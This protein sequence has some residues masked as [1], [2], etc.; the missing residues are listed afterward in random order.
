MGDH[1]PKILVLSRNYPNRAVPLLGVWVEGL[2]KHCLDRCDLKVISVVPYCPPL[3][4]LGTQFTR[5]RQVEH[6]RTADGIEILHPRFLLA[7]GYRFHRF[8][9]ASYYGSVSGLVD[10]LRERFPFEI[11]HA[12]FS[13]PDGCVA[14][15]LG[16]RYG[17]PVVVTEHA[18][19]RPWMDEHPAVLRQALAAY[20]HWSFLVG[21][22]TNVREEVRHFAGDSPKL[23]VIPL[24]VDGSVFTLGNGGMSFRPRQILFAGV[25]RHVKGLDILLKAMRLLADRNDPATLVV[26]GE[27]FYPKYQRAFQDAR[28]LSEELKLQDRV[29]FAGKKTQAELARTMRDSAVLVMPSRKESLGLVLVEALACGTPVVA[30][31]CGGPEDIVTEETGL[32]VPPDD[33]EALATAVQQVLDHRD[34]Y[35]PATLREYA[36]GKFA[37]QHV[38]AQYIELYQ[39]AL[40]L[41]VRQ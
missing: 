5:F 29:E 4:G 33:P 36:L 16:A 7:P 34:E 12:H 39:D 2:V 18:P 28:L 41:G 23:R 40:A 1:R 21:V 11:I 22:G 35:S 26:V 17:V 31:R 20:E 3:P 15:K 6:A 13:Y 27:S 9:A 25:I 30:T 37:W 8:E 14:A 10:R 19:W 24:G 38:A 32:L